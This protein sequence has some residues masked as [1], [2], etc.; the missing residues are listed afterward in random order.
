MDPTKPQ[1]QIGQCI[2]DIRL[3]S[4]IGQGSFAVVFLGMRRNQKVAVKCLYKQGLTSSQLA[5]QMSEANL[6]T[7]LKHDNIIKLLETIE[8]DDCV[9]LVLEYCETDLFDFIMAS[10]RPEAETKRL[11]S[12]LCHAVDFCHQMNVYHRDLKP[13]NVLLIAGDVKLADFGLATQHSLS[14]EF[15]CG[16]VRYMAP[17]CLSGVD[18][19]MPLPYS[20]AANDVWSLGIILINLLTGKNPW[21][22]PSRKDKHFK[23]HMGREMERDSFQLQFGFTDDLCHLLRRVFDLD[24]FKRPSALELAYLVEEIPYLL[25]TSVPSSP[26]PKLVPHDSAKDLVQDDLIFKIDDYQQQPNSP[27]FT[28]KKKQRRRK[29][30]VRTPRSPSVHTSPWP[31]P[32]TET[33]SPKRQRAVLAPPTPPNDALSSVI[34]S[35]ASVLFEAE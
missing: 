32:P 21:V 26:V 17:E 25:C 35:L 11:F 29:P 28:L 12:Q 6:L 30:S 24:P 5:L 13:E 20:C 31:S 18:A 4:V 14:N 22:E 1:S 33:K 9:Y 16:S 7:T 34:S 10:S 19:G 23:A 2:G 8:T 15:G 27:V 3:V